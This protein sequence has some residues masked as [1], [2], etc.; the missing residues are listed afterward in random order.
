MTDLGWKCK[1]CLHHQSAGE[2][3]EMGGELDV[4]AENA[5]FVSRVRNRLS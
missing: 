3:Y 5:R 4:I 1:N 2:L